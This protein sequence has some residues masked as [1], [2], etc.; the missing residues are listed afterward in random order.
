MKVLCIG[1]HP[2]DLEFGSAGTLIKY[3]EAGSEVFLMLMTRGAM[4]GEPEVRIAEQIES[5]KIIGVKDIFWGGFKDTK[6]VADAESIGAVEKI[7][8][9][10]QPDMIFSPYGEDTHQDHRTLYNIVMSAARNRRNLLLYETPTTAPQFNPN[11]FVD[12]TQVLNKKVKTLLA[13]HS[14]IMKTNIQDTSILDMVTSAA[15]FRGVQARV[16]YAEGFMSVR[17]FLELPK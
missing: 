9:Q 10:V 15:N 1:P 14:Q 13:H 12:I 4:G 6:L 8:I 2:D 5:G 3:A 11:V 7:I 16:R 17:L